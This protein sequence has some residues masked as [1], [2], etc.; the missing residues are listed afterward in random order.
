MARSCCPS[1]YGIVQIVARTAAWMTSVTTLVILAFII[2]QWP[3]KG[4][5]IAAGLVG[6]AIAILN[7]SWIVVANIDRA[8]GFRQ[9]SPARALLHDLFSLAVSLGG[10]VMII[11]SR[12]S[13]AADGFAALDSDSAPQVA[14]GVGQTDVISREGFSQVH[15]MAIAVWLL[16]S[17]VIC[18]FVFIIW[19]GFEC[20]YEFRQIHAQPLRRREQDMAEV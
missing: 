10:I 18:R 12:Y 16:T 6:S 17:V 15:M 1:F 9:L 20:L 13:Y 7:D 14:S 5:A 3:D 19:G 2:N 8:L 4:G 11:F